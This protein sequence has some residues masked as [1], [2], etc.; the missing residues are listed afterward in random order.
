VDGKSSPSATLERLS[1]FK[2]EYDLGDDDEL[3]LVIDRDRWKPKMIADVARE[4]R[5][6]RFNMAMSNPCFEVWL[7]LHYTKEIPP[8][9][10]STTADRYFRG[11][12]GAYSKGNFDPLPLLHRVGTAVK[13][14]DALDQPKGR[15]WPVGVGSHVYLLIQSIMAAGVR[16]PDGTAS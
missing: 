4:C 11:I 8:K 15:R 13:N 12:H 14:A 10:Q 9:L 7:A 2:D 6:Q 5:A 16:L 1:Q 3:W